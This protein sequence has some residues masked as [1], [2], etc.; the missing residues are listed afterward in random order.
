MINIK[1]LLSGLFQLTTDVVMTIPVHFIRNLYLKP[2]LGS[3]GKHSELCRNLDIRSPKR[4]RIG[5]NT[6]INKYVVLDGRG[7]ILSIGNNV[8]IAQDCRIWTLQ[9]DY[10]S[11][12]YAAIGGDVTISDYVWIASGATV[13][14]GLTIGEGA[15]VATGAIVT[16]DVPPYSIVAGVPA[17]KIGERNRN[18][19]YKLGNRRWFH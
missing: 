13:L 16:K 12:D 4:I 19:T 14:P 15:V 6:T 7:G 3:R 5:S 18:L 2:F 11:P 8:D 17:K 9:H 10:N 1:G